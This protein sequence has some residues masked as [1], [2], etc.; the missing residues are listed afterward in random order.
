MTQE[1]GNVQVVQVLLMGAAGAVIALLIA[2]RYV[3]PSSLA[4]SPRRATGLRPLDLLV[5]FLLLLIAGQVAGGILEA[6]GVRLHAGAAAPTEAVVTALVG[7]VGI[8]LPVAVYALLRAARRRWGLRHFGLLPRRLK[9]ELMMAGGALVAAMPLVL[10]TNVLCV[11]VSDWLGLRTSL[12]GHHMLEVLR[13]TQELWVLVMLL[14]SALAIAPLLEEILFRGLV[15]TCLLELLGRRRRW[16]I[17]LLAAFLF[18]GVHWES[19]VWQVMPGLFVLG[20]VLG[21]LYERTGSL[22]PSVIVHMGFNAVMIA[23]TLAAGPAPKHD[24]LV[25]LLGG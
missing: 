15:Q 1:V 17:I 5:G 8:Q 3:T 24:V 19:A 12:Y 23:A 16:G 2:L 10:G 7:Q 9:R 25:M 13:Q 4:G 20:V 18:A 11:L 22:L 6:L 21:W 14:V